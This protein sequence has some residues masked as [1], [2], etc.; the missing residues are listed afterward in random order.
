MSTLLVPTVSVFLPFILQFSQACL[1]QTQDLFGSI[2]FRVL[3]G[4]L[5]TFKH[6]F[7]RIMIGARLLPS[8]LGI[9]EV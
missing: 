3:I 8:N 2:Q 7:P 5:Q 9:F 6:G 1:T 4:A